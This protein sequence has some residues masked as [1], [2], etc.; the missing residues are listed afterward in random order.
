MH[1]WFAQLLETYGYWAVALVVM[2]ESLGLPVPGETLLLL[3]AASAGAGYLE[4]WGVIGVAAG[5]ALVGDSLG[6]AL[7]RWGGRPPRLRRRRAATLRAALPLLERYGRVL[8]LQPR[9]LARAEAFFARYGGRS[10]WGASSPSCAPIVR[11]SRG[12]RACPTP[13]SCSGTRRNAGRAV[14]LQQQQAQP[15]AYWR[16]R[17]G[18]G[19]LLT[20]GEVTD[21]EPH[22]EP[23][24]HHMA[25]P[26]F[27]GT[28]LVR[29]HPCLTFASLEAGFQG[30]TVF[31]DP[32]LDSGVIYRNPALLHQFFDMPIAQG[33][34]DGPA[35]T[36]QDNILGEMGPLEA[37][38]HGRSLSLYTASHRERPY[39]KSPPMKICDI[40]GPAEDVKV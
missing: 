5:G 38:R 27:P 8:H 26:A 20:P 2:G 17:Q 25:M 1:A 31:D 11:S 30:G 34:R 37:H 29:V 19:Y 14:D 16:Q 12:S 6:Y 13:A 35:H 24:Q 28:A 15:V 39:H 18:R 32:A 22:R 3:G 10:A 21:E 40:Y 23:G 9:H 7:G 36:H 33:I 4:V